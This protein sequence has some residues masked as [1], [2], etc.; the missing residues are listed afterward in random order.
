MAS[1]ICFIID[2]QWVTECAGRF[3]EMHWWLPLGNVRRLA[4]NV[5]A[6]L[7]LSIVPSPLVSRYLRGYWLG[8]AAMAAQIFIS[9]TIA[10]RVRLDSAI[11]IMHAM[12]S[13][14]T[15]R[16]FATRR[17]PRHYLA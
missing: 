10:I 8:R 9:A 5:A 14:S 13:R 16:L 3:L 4:S 17:A 7:F 1:T 2:G 12:A 6:V 11:A 15:S